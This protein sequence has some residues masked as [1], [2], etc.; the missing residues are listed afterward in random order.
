MTAI[1][2]EKTTLSNGIDVILHQDHSIPVVAVNV[3]YHVGSKDEEMGRTGFA[4]LFEHIMFEGSKHHNKS[5]FDPL[6]KAGAN[7]NGSTTLDRTN[8]WEDVPSNY[9]ELAL[10]LESDRMGFLLEALDQQRFDIQRDVVKN[11][12]RQTYENRPYGL[13]HQNIQSALFPLPH[14]YHWMTIGSQEDLDAASLEDVKSFFERYYSPSNAS[15]AIAGDFPK[16]RCLGVGEPLLR[17]PAPRP[18]TGAERPSGLQPSRTRRT[19]DAG[20][21]IPSPYIHLLAD[22]SGFQRRRRSLGVA[23]G[24]SLPTA[25]APGFTAPWFTRS[26]SLRPFPSGTARPRSPVNSLFRL[27]RP[28]ATSWP[29]WRRPPTRKWRGFHRNR[30]L[31]KRLPGSRTGSSQA[32]TGNSPG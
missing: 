32:T 18:A 16:R 2:F 6:Q 15:L 14:P 28:P 26:K 31:K 27:R 7:L 24:D 4:H 12:R 1:S 10:W 17:R 3:W 19:G 29:R 23:G 9:L 25:S 13:A 8:Y 20:Q 30:P 21:G 5:Y 11:E 22:P